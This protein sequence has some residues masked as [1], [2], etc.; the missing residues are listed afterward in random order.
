AI[1]PLD[2]GGKT[3]VEMPSRYLQNTVEQ[4]LL[5]S[6]SLIVLSTYLSEENM[7]FVPFLV[8][9]F[10]IARLVFAVGYFMDPIKRSLGYAM[11]FTP[12][13]LVIGY[14]LYCL[15]IYGFEVYH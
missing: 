8:V 2:Q 13:N 6:F 11:T 10:C 14:C 1:N 15:L 5:H 9:L 7:N 12:T 4:F 3:F